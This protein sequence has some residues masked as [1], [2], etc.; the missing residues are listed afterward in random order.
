MR[1]LGPF[2]VV[3]LDALPTATAV[4]DDAREGSGRVHTAGM[5]LRTCR[6]MQAT[7]AQGEWPSFCLARCH[8]SAR[9]QSRDDRAEGCIKKAKPS[10]YDRK[11]KRACPNVLQCLLIE[12]MKL[13]AMLIASQLSLASPSKR[14]AGPARRCSQPISPDARTAEAVYKTQPLTCRL[15]ASSSQESQ[16]KGWKP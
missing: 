4:R 14:G 9:D 2:F 5:L 13:A 6:M 8:S 16:L 3:R 15:T 12:R 7:M 10:A 1:L 11:N